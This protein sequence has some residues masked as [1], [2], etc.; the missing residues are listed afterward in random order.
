[1]FTLLLPPRSPHPGSP[2][3][4]SPPLPLSSSP[5]FFLLLLPP[6]FALFFFFAFCPLL[7]SLESLPLPLPL[8]QPLPKTGALYGCF[9]I[10]ED[11][12]S[13][14]LKWDP[15]G[16]IPLRAYK[17]YTHKEIGGTNREVEGKKEESP[18]GETEVGAGTR[19][20]NKGEEEEEGSQ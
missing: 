5:F 10:P 15:L 13:V 14:I 12:I 4:S 17:L 2:P 7:F 16:N 9:G 1:M 18:D 8:P 6:F 20:A 3:P 11:W 19:K